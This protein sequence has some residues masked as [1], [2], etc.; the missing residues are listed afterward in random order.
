[1]I[2]FIVPSVSQVSIKLSVV[3]VSLFDWGEGRGQRNSSR[4]SVSLPAEVSFQL[5][6][7]PGAYSWMEGDNL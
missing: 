3:N 5:S 1:M 2:P 4:G 7:S 6:G